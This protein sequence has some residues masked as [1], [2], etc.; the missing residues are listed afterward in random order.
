MSRSYKK[1]KP[2]GFDF[3]SR[4]CFG[5]MCAASGPF[6]KQVTKKKERTRNKRIERTAVTDPDVVEGRFPGE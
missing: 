5:N 3:W 6:S 2:L 4:R 1:S